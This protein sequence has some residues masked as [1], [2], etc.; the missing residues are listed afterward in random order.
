VTVSRI[1]VVDDEQHIRW[2][3]STLLG[4]EGYETETAES[5]ARAL[6]L[7]REREPDLAFLDYRLPDTDGLELLRKIRK[8]GYHFPVIMITAYESVKNAVLSIKEGAF[9]YLTK[10]LDND[11]ILYHARR[12]LE[13][14]QLRRQVSEYKTRLS[15]LAGPDTLIGSSR[16][17]GE[18][19]ETVERVAAADISVLLSGE[20]GTG[21]E[22]V[23]H[24]I[25]D[26]SPRRAGP[27]VTVDCGTLPETLVESELYGHEKGAFT[28]AERRAQ[29]KFELCRGG[30][31]FLDEVGNA[32]SPL[33]AKLLRAIEGKPFTRLGG[34]HPVTMDARVV[35]ASN[36]DLGEMVDGGTFRRDLYYR[37]KGMEVRLPPL[38]E[39]PGDIPELVDWFAGRYSR[40]QHKP[41]PEIL[42]EALDRLA[43]Y[44]WPGNVREL[45]NVIERAVL[46]SE[47]VIGAEHLPPETGAG[48]E[49]AAGEAAD[50]SLR[51]LRRRALDGTER[52]AVV[53]ALEAS[54]GNRRAA[55]RSLNVDPK[56]FYRLLDRYGLK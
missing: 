5:G 9:D 8:E 39:H 7:V 16:A 33:Q 46:L 19:L 1:L 43:A 22:L 32:P 3:F 6:A 47:G 37:L 44:G 29:G 48:R 55:A 54:R 11:E 42:P 27:F 15:E 2:I 12:A 41:K 18:V 36:R 21:K 38:R 53:R 28:G 49:G 25:H 17:V 35:A 40:Q 13:I 24:L 50:G 56:T 26:R 4:A 31:L 20:S 30:T 45:R 34:S 10:P 23:A 14:S 52:E 51:S